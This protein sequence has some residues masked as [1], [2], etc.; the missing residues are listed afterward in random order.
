MLFE[1]GFEDGQLLVG[2]EAAEPFGG[3]EHAS[4]GPAQ[5]HLRIAPALHIAADLPDHGI[6]R[7]DDVGACQRP[8]QFERQ[9]KAYDG[10]D[11]IDAFE[12][13]LR[14]PRCLEFEAPGQIAEKAFGLVD[15]VHLP[16]LPQGAAHGGVNLRRDAWGRAGR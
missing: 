14:H 12:D 3:F 8:P 5:G 4:G 16:G 1:S 13:A 9:A 7:V 15:V 11:L 2:L 10:E 6:H